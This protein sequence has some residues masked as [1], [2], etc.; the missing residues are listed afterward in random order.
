MERK[1]RET[2]WVPRTL[3]VETSKGSTLVFGLRKSHGGTSVFP[4][5]ALLEKLDAFKTLE[6]GTFAADGGA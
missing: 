3:K 1:R 4:F 6:N 5:T 2:R